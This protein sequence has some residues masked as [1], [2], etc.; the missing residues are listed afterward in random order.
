[1]YFL[2][3]FNM[4]LLRSKAG[5]PS[6]YCPNLG[7]LNAD[8]TGGDKGPLPDLQILAACMRGCVT[9]RG[10]HGVPPLQL[11]PRKSTAHFLNSQSEIRN[12]K[13]SCFP[14]SA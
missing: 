1:M 9:T 8:E 12:P 6:M 3:C 14:L 13:F 2:E 5:Q 4:L 10:G 11:H 7:C